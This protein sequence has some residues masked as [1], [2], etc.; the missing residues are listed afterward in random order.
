ML[1]CLLRENPF[2]DQIGS[3]NDAQQVSRT[4]LCRFR[5]PDR[6]PVAECQRLFSVDWIC[7]GP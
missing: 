3:G 7:V 2:F 4:L 6:D 1:I 5:I